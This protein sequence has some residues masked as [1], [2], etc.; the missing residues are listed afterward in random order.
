MKLEA[1]AACQR[2]QRALDLLLELGGELDV[3]HGAA[4]AADQV[5]VV[6]EQVLGELEAG[7]VAAPTRR[8]TSPVSSKTERLG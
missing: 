1:L 2:G 5:V 3:E 6:A 8:W 7:E 4:A